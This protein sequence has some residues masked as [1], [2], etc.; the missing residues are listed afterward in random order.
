MRKLLLALLGLAALSGSAFAVDS[1]TG[2]GNANY[3]ATINDIRI[4][5][6]VAFSSTRT[7]TLPS[8]G[9][10]MIG[11]GSQG[12]QIL[13]G[14]SA[15]LEV[16]DSFGN[17]GGSNSC[18]TIA[19]ASGETV[20]GGASISFCSTYGTVTLYP[21]SGS[22]WTARI[23][24]PGQ[25]MGTTTNDN[26]QAGFVGEF[27]S[28]SLTSGQGLALT[29]ATVTNLLSLSLT[30]GDWDCRATI[31]RT[32]GAT[33]TVSR[34]SQSIGTTSLTFATE[35]TEGALALGFSNLSAFAAGTAYDTKIT[36]T[37]ISASGTTTVYLVVAD[38]F[39]TSTDTAFGVL[40]CRRVR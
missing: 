15:A 11:Q 6:I 32:L 5:P 19:A 24:G 9:G 7:L 13:A 40:G 31:A 30:G 28:T 33:T 25:L 36:P 17:V 3:T 21:V 29:T 12:P 22:Q 38:T 2:M 39:L 37:R 4:I 20:N 27:Q 35:G 26:A 18:M 1:Y 8:A 23:Y 10:T 14:S 34:M 16:L